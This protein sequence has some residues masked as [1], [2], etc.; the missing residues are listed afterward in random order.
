[1]SGDVFT[2]R[3]GEQGSPLLAASHSVRGSESGGAPARG[4][5]RLAKLEE[6]V[7]RL[8][9]MVRFLT[10]QVRQLTTVTESTELR[11]GGPAIHV[12][13]EP[14]PVDRAVSRVAPISMGPS[15]PGAGMGEVKMATFS[16]G[17]SRA[18]VGQARVFQG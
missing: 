15:A 2:Y 9:E 10:E 6:T 16:G 8:D 3:S 12:S 14:P 4:R 13:D 5:E 18:T 7:S 11:I 1:M 17:T